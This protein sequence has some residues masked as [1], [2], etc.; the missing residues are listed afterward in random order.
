MRIKTL[1][2][3]AILHTAFLFPQTSSWNVNAGGNWSNSA[4]WNNGA[5]ITAGSAAIFGPVILAP[6]TVTVDIA[7]IVVGSMTFNNTAAAYTIAAASTNTLNLQ[8]SAG[9]TAITV[10][11]LTDAAH[12]I[13]TPMVITNP[14]TITQNSTSNPLTISGVM[15][16]ASSVT[17]AGAG[18]IIFSAAN[19]Y[20]G[21][22]T[23]T[24]GELDL[25]V[26]SALSPSGA[27]TLTAGTIKCNAVNTLP[28]TGTTTVNSGTLNINDNNQSAGPIA[29]SGGSITL[30]VIPATT[31]TSTTSTSTTYGGVISGSGAFTLA[32]SGGTLILTA[33]NTYSGGTTING[34]TLQS[35]INNVLLP[36]GNLTVNSPGV[37]NLNNFNQ[38]VAILSGSGSITLGSGNLTTNTVTNSTFSGIISGTGTFT[39]Q[40]TSTLQLTGVNTYTGGTT[41]STGTLQL[42]VNNALAPTGPV[43]VA[44]GILDISPTTLQAI[45][46]LTGSTNITL[47]AAQL[48]INSVF[49][50]SYS[51]VIS[52]TGSV[53]I[54]GPLNL[55][56]TNNQSYSGGTTVS[57]GSLILGTANALLPTGNLAVNSPGTFNLAGFNQTVGV[58]SGNGSI[59]LGGGIFT[60][61]TPT[62]MTSNFSG[63]ISQA[64]SLVVGD[65]I[66][67]GTLILTGANSY[68]GGTTVNTNATLQGTTTSLQGT[69]A[70]AGT[71]NFNQSF[72]GTFTGTLAGA[73][74]LNINGGNI[75]FTSPQTQGNTLVNTG[76]L[77]LS[78]TTL[79]SPV[80]VASGASLGPA[81]TSTI[82]GATTVNGTLA[83][84]LGTLNVV[85][86]YLQG[87]GSTFDVEVTPSSSGFLPAAGTVTLQGE[88]AIDIFFQPGL[89]APS[90]TYTLITAGAP[91]V[92][93]FAAPVFE[94]PFFNGSLIYNA[95]GLGSVQLVLNIV[96]FGNVIKGGN[97]GAIAKCINLQ[98]FPS[99]SDLLPALQTLIFLPTQQIKDALEEMQPSQLK[100]FDIIEENNLVLVRTAISQR[101]DDLNRTDWNQCISEWYKWT[102]WS[103]LSGDFLRQEDNTGN[104]GFDANTASAAIGSDVRLGEHYYLGF[105]GAYNYS[106]L[107]WDKSRGHGNIS[108]YYAGPYFSCY[109]HRVFMTISAL[110]TWNNYH[111]SRHIEF[112]TVNRHAVSD[113]HGLGLI[114]HFDIGFMTYPAEQMTF[115]PFGGLDYIF[116][117]EKGYSEKGAGSLNMKIQPTHGALLRSELGFKIA[118]CA[119]LAHNKWTQD[120]K[121]SWIHQHLLR[122]KR[123]HAQFSEVNCTFTVQGIRPNQ[124]YFDV[125]AGITGMFRQDRLAA[126]LR[127]EGK[128]GDGILDNTVYVQL[129]FRY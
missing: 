103:N 97:A 31:L 127:Y 49:S 65:T 122:G 10:T 3:A 43:A 9:T 87:A 79:T 112:P 101:T 111:A 40:G 114:S 38:T 71:V 93:T 88:P 80:T 124:D 86:N 11:N 128:F 2:S 107:Q 24:A 5:P 7:T 23:V 13:S 22:T 30:G 120:L 109:N 99:E 42:G 32:G 34:S 119:V 91:V 72:D 25:N 6:Q 26:T 110:G 95:A 15:S 84:G 116:L 41:I 108:S 28:S 113:H 57:G 55:T 106:W 17:T 63:I 58:L 27:L 1:F 82:I 51:G 94:N 54:A 117:W 44:G 14:L 75:T 78:N 33:A 45:G 48:T 104:V 81:G 89:F 36:T 21:G 68:S 60:V 59:T 69:I 125:A 85:G 16:G 70:N 83:L 20:T 96:P 90:T 62:G 92:G 102:L 123:L 35:G 73:G 47:G 105:A 64:G 118:K 19:S 67:M 98:A 100:A 77:I 56:L 66:T 76:E 61:N 37:F 126:G 52:G 50:T 4:N 8:G 18:V 53:V 29:G 12:V 39:K 74:T 46:P 115:S 129:T 121:L